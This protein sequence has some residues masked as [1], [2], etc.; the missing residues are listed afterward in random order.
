MPPGACADLVR[1]ADSAG[2]AGIFVSCTDFRA[3]EVVDA[4]ERELG[5]PVLTSNQVTCGPSCARCGR[6]RPIAGFGRLLAC[7][8]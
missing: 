4:L 1:I 2:R 8:A 6:T 5:K 3:L 7:A